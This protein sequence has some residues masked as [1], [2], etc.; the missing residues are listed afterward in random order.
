MVVPQSCF[1]DGSGLSDG[2]HHVHPA[3]RFPFQVCPEKL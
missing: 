1:S 3:V 2:Y